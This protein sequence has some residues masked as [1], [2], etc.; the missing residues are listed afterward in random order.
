M[1]LFAHDK[2]QASVDAKKNRL[3]E[4]RE[5][6]SAILHS[7]EGVFSD[8]RILSEKLTMRQNAFCRRKAQGSRNLAVCGLQLPVSVYIEVYGRGKCKPDK[9]RKIK[10]EASDKGKGK[11]YFA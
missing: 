8:G 10:L 2:T 11:I 3:S 7:L 5:W 9:L 1:F 6:L 4:I